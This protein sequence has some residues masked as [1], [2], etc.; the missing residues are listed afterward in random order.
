MPRLIPVDNERAAL[1]NGKTA[2]GHLH[3]VKLN[4]D[5]RRLGIIISYRISVEYTSKVFIKT[6]WNRII[7]YAI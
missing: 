2:W 4:V 1:G 7:F 3:C 5:E 6:H